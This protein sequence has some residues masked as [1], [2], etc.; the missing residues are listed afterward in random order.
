MTT[1]ANKS[2]PDRNPDGKTQ[3]RN[4]QMRN[5]RTREE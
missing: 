3:P 5:Q 4:R 1:A 2:L